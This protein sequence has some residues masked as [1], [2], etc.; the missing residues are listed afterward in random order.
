MFHVSCRRFQFHFSCAF[1]AFVM[2]C[3]PRKSV[4]LVYYHIIFLLCF[5]RDLHNHPKRERLLY[6]T[7]TVSILPTTPHGQKSMVSSC[8][9]AMLQLP[10]RSFDCTYI[11]TF[12]FNE[13]LP[14]GYIVSLNAG[15]PSCEHYI[16]QLLVLWKTPVFIYTL[17]AC[18]F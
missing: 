1:F 6:L 8:A 10:S 2:L 16:Q 12:I 11:P 14:L 15:T 3:M 9:S 17:F 18:P 5:R 7:N 13:L 4:T